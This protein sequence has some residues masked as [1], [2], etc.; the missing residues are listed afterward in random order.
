M[1]RRLGV[2]LGVVGAGVVALVVAEI[3]TSGHAPPSRRVAPPL[4]TALLAG[5]RVDLAQLR[6]RPVIVSFWASWCA[7][8]EREAG[9]LEQVSRSLAGRATVVGIDW[10][11]AVGGA[12]HFVRRHGWTFTVLRDPDG[13]TG[14]RYQLTGL[15]TTF[16]LDRGGR[17][18][19]TLRGPQS[20]PGLLRAVQVASA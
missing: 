13:V 11:D 9:A 18:A 14:E 17:I 10:S 7:P 1:R 19:V 3:A 20:V 15:P 4:P 2:T 16:V 6:G 5:S 8:C 12:R